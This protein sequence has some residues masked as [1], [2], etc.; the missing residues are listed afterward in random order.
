M[1]EIKEALERRC[2]D[3]DRF[4]GF[5]DA[6]TGNYLPDSLDYKIVGRT[7]GVCDRCKKEREKAKQ[8]RAENK[9]KLP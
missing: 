7:D 4:L 3:C 1:K 5:R 9:P 6:F 8:K 2:C